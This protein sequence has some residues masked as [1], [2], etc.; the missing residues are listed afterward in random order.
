MQQYDEQRLMRPAQYGGLCGEASHSGGA[1][2]RSLSS[3]VASPH[4][5]SPTRINT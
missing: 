5:Q 1:V 2:D 3:L 4:E